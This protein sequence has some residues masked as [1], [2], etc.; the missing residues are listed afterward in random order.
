MKIEKYLLL[1]LA[2]RQ[3][4]SLAPFYTTTEIY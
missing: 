3:Y 1:M 4:R 2:L